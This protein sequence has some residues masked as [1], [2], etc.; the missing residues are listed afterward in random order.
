MVTHLVAS[1]Y[2]LQVFDNL[3]V[4]YD[5]RDDDIDMFIGGMLETTANGP[6]ELFQHLILDQFMRIRDADRLW[7]ENKD[8]G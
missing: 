6:G 4:L 2:V 1:S 8:N 7:F 5:G 3:T